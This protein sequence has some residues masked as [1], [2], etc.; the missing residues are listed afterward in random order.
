MKH[1]H[2]A[3][4]IAAWLFFGCLAWEPILGEAANQQAPIL[5][6][7]NAQAQ[8]QPLVQQ[9][10]NGIPLVQITAPTAGGVS[11]NE[12]SNFNVPEKGAVLNNS[13]TVVNTQLAGYVQGNPNMAR[14]T[15]KI[16]VNEVTSSRPTNMNGFLEV[17]GDRASVVIANPNGI[18]VNGGGF[19]NTAQAMLTTGKPQYDA[20]GNLNSLHVTGGNVTIAGNGLDATQTDKLSILS[21]AVAVNAG[22]WAKEA[23]YRGE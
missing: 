16:I 8:H 1:K 19:I 2:V 14:G 9:T 3:I 5:P 23:H 11:R 10:A 6:D 22:I 21:R 18:S 4:K 17:A 20:Q 13:H 7:T 12:Y 15:A